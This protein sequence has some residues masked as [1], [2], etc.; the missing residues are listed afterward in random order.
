MDSDMNYPF[1]NLTRMWME[2]AANAMQAC[3]PLAGSTASP[4]MF[5]TGRA[6]FMQVWSDWCEEM[7][8]SSAFLEAQK[9][10]I[11]GSLGLRKQIRTNLRRV[12][13]ELQI[14]GR[15]DIDALVAAVKRSQRRVLDQLEETSERLQA[16]ETKLDCLSERLERFMGAAAGASDP[17]DGATI[18]AAVESNGGKKIR[19]HEEKQ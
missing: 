6:D 3:Q 13:R 19:R 16:L 1:S 18:R 8:R 12:Q 4:D 14:A 10:C 9:Q 7:M 17:E 2:M 15:D 11:N 5:R